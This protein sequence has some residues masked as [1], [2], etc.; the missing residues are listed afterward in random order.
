M[1]TIPNDIFTLIDNGPPGEVLVTPAYGVGNQSW[2]DWKL[3]WLRS[4]HLAADESI[5]SAGFP[6]FMNLGEGVGKFNV[7]ERE[8]LERAGQDLYAT[9]KIDGSLLI[10]Y[11]QDGQV[12]WRTRG[13]LRIG[14]DNA[15]EI[16]YFCVEYPLLADPAFCP[17]I[18][19]LF[20]WVSP[21]NKIV[22]SYVRPQLFLIGGVAFDRG[23]KWWEANL[24]LLS[25]KEL[26]DV[27]VALGVE[28]P[29]YYLLNSEREVTRLIEDL[30]ADT[31]IEGFVLRFDQGQRLVK[32]KT[33][34]YRTL[35][36]LRSCLT[37]SMLIDLWCQW[38]KPSYV[39]YAKLFDAAYDFECWQWA[40]P[41]VS[42]MFDGIRVAERIMA[43]IRSF[44]E[45]NRHLIR[46]DF[47]LLAQQ[48]YDS[49]RLATCFMLLD[50][51]EPKDESWKKLI[52]QNCKEVEL[53]MF[54]SV[55]LENDDG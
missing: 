41:G 2:Q 14:L 30:K 34:H 13:S 40:M 32:I 51:K 35:H 12:K 6:K 5:I 43:H 42:S 55:D 7:D 26:A 15:S 33:E 45:E 21:L 4:L 1:I 18:S 29:D 39:E 44:V 25:M 46:K 48:K 11:V 24:R 23:V 37:T 20:E 47:A 19:L 17:D 50:G 38:G 36:A 52:L 9:L 49:V 27:E 16:E 8:L 54:Q 22:I 53:R 10:R 28:M 3:R 31:T